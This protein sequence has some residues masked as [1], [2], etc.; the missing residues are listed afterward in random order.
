MDTTVIVALIT[1]SGVIFTGVNQLISIWLKNRVENV[2][3]KE[4]LKRTSISLEVDKLCANLRT[5]L[6]ADHV[7]I[8]KF[9]NGGSFKSGLPMD[10]FTVY[11][12]DYTANTKSL[13]RVYVNTLMTLAPFTF[14]KLLVEGF[15]FRPVV[16]QMV[17]KELK[18][19]LMEANLYSFFA[20]LVKDLSGNPIAFIAVGYSEFRIL[21]SED[22]NIYWKY[23]N[24]FLKIL[25][26]AS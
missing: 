13:K 6:N 12:E 14:H 20:I 4:L 16:S 5:E 24:R 26:S 15:C 7:F 18:E 1:L 11:G 19:D 8:G 3:K 9:H 2:H 17:D 23:H 10:K 25:T 22:R 21:T